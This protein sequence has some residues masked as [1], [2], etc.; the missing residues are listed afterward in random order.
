MRDFSCSRPVSASEEIDKAIIDSREQVSN[1]SKIA[2][3]SP[4]FTSVS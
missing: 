1:N 3:V 4:T 2:I